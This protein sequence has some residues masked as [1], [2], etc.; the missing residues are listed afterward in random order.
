[1]PVYTLTVSPSVRRQLQRLPEAAATALV[2]ALTGDL[3]VTPR[4]LENHSR[5]D[6]RTISPLGGV[7]G[8]LS[9][10]STTMIGSFL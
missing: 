8:E 2:E 9:T 7:R 1:M 10:A 5:A 4:R 3:L 6:G